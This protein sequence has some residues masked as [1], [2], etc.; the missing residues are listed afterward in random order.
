MVTLRTA[1]PEPV[2]V[3]VAAA[4]P[5]YMTVTSVSANVTVSA[6][7]YVTVNVTGSPVELAAEGEPTMTCGAVLSAVKSALGPAARAALPAASVAVSCPMEIP[8]VPSPVMSETVTM[9]DSAPVP[10]MVTVPLA[11]P[12][13][14]SAMSPVVKLTSPGLESA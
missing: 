11:V 7:V 5:V 1:A 12:V 8:R 6:P 10:A 4:V 14:F 3:A 13:L 2:T 9:R